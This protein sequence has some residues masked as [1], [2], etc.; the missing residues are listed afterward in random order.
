M[1][2]RIGWGL[3][4]SPFLASGSKRWPPAAVIGEFCLTTAGEAIATEG[5]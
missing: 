5:N 3:H 1:T 2:L 4:R